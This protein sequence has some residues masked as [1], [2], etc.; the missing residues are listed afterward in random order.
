MTNREIWIEL[1]C[2]ENGKIFE[3]ESK[4]S[5]RKLFAQ[6]LQENLIFYG[7]IN[8]EEEDDLLNI[9]IRK[10]IKENTLPTAQKLTRTNKLKEILK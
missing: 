5:F 8:K 7:I 9:Y 10:K 2:E 6:Q 3:S 4:Q 1:K